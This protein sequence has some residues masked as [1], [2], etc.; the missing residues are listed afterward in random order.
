MLSA[1]RT[2]GLLK[3]TKNGLHHR[4]KSVFASLSVG[5]EYKRQHRGE[6]TSPVLSFRIGMSKQSE[7]LQSMQQAILVTVVRNI[8]GGCLRLRSSIPHGDTDA[9]GAQHFYVVF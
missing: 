8:I 4:M 6:V 9:G 1:E 7:M 5:R 3:A 2:G